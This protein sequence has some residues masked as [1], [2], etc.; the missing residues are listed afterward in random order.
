MYGFGN[1]FTLFTRKILSQ[2]TQPNCH[3]TERLIGMCQLGWVA[4][5]TIFVVKTHILFFFKVTLSQG[6]NSSN[7]ANPTQ[8]LQAQAADRYVTCQESWVG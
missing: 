8:L 4:W 6:Y 5:M 7:L 2:P 1:T 3:R